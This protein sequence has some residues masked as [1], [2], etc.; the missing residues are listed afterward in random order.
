M[1]FATIKVVKSWDLQQVGGLCRPASYR[2]TDRF[3][4]ELA[5]D[6]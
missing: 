1:I 4:A 2:A 5:P 6:W 3:W